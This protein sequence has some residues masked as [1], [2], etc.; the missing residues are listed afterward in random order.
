MWDNFTVITKLDSSSKPEKKIQCNHCKNKY[1][2]N[3]HKKGTN[4][5]ILH[6]NK[7]KVKVRNGDVDKMTI[8]TKA[9]L[10]TR[11]IDHSIFS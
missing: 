5:L 6:R 4:C 10:Q 11:K 2:H 7:C 9:K 3:S 1:V 8:D